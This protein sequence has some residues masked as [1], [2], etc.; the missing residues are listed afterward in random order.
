MG[1]LPVQEEPAMRVRVSGFLGGSSAGFVEGIEVGCL[2]FVAVLI[3]GG[4]EAAAFC[5]AFLLGLSLLEKT[6]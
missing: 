2:P 3:E 5:L 1:S 6:M 4:A